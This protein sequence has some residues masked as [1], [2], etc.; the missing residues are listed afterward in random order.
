MPMLASPVRRGDE[1]AGVHPPLNRLIRRSLR[2]DADIYAS[3]DDGAD[4]LEGNGG[5]EGGYTIFCDAGSTGTR[6]YVFRLS[7]STSDVEMTSVT[8]V[9]PGLSSQTPESAT[10]YLNSAL[11]EA[12]PLIPPPYRNTTE[13]FV[14]ATAGMRLLKNE[15]QRDIY[16]ALAEGL[17]SDPEMPFLVKRSNLRT[18]SG[19]DEGYYA[20]LAV[21]YLSN[22]LG[23]DLVPM[24]VNGAAGG[25]IGALDLGGSSTQIVFDVSEKKHQLREGRRRRTVR[26]KDFYSHS[27]LGFGAQKFRELLNGEVARLGGPSQRV[28]YQ[29]EDVGSVIKNPCYFRGYNMTVGGKMHVGTG[30]GDRCAVAVQS[31]INGSNAECVK[32]KHCALLG[33]SQPPLSGEFV[34]MSV[35]YY[36]LSFALGFMAQV[37]EKVNKADGIDRRMEPP[38]RLTNPTIEEMEMAASA[39]CSLDYDI[40]SENLTAFSDT[41]GPDQ[42]PHRCLEVYYIS[43]LLRSYG[44]GGHDRNVMIADQINGEDVEWTL[45][46]YLHQSAESVKHGGRIFALHDHLPHD[47]SLWPHGSLVAAMVICPLV[48][49]GVMLLW[50]LRRKQMQKRAPKYVIISMPSFPYPDGDEEEEEEEEDEEDDED[51]NEEVSQLL[52]NGRPYQRRLLETKAKI[53]PRP[54]EKSVFE[55]SPERCLSLKQRCLQQ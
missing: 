43:G 51:D 1:S 24:A 48:F 44:F 13:V 12:V 6:L 45:G 49:F 30:D 40:L 42:L 26:R 18:I 16:D 53:S 9:Y 25:L 4:L 31:V 32:G 2:N 37:E 54:N 22:R 21:N 36:S 17:R 35:Y 29:E 15:E 55:I 41:T 23:A 50:F 33:V 27:F 8:K 28:D 38:L 7:G 11:T 20:L 10:S 47:E 46:A 3:S 14:L 5:P 52:A 39:L 19:E 34:A